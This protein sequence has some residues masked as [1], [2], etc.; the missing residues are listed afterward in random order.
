MIGI[1][2]CFAHE[3]PCQIQFSPRMIDGMSWT[4]GENVE[5]F[6]SDSRYVIP[7]NRTTGAYIRRQILTNLSMMI[8]RSRVRNFP[9]ACRKKLRKMLKIGRDAQ[10][11]LTLYCNSN[12]ISIEILQ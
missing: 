9:H 2:H 1:F 6:W 10:N 8:G 3:F 5:R 12:N 11:E 7:V 4:D